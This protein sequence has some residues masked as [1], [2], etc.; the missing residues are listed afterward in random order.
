MNVVYR[1]EHTIAELHAFVDLEIAIWGLAA[2]D[3]VPASL[4]CTVIRN[5]GVLIGAYAE[6]RAQPVGLAFGFPV[7]RGN[8]WLL[9]SHMT[10]VHP[11][12]QRQGIGLELKRRQRQW[13]LNNGFTQMRWTFD[14]LQA[15]N[16]HFNLSLLG[17]QADRYHVDY[18]GEMG[19][20]INAHLPSDRVE[21]VWDL[22]SA[23]TAERTTAPELP[24]S[25]D[26]F[27]L[28]AGPN[29]QPILGST[30]ADHS[31]HLYVEIPARLDL[32]RDNQAAQWR[33]ALRSA[34]QPA[35]ERGFVISG[36]QRKGGR[37]W[38]VLSA[39]QPWFVYVLECADGSLYTGTTKNPA[40][41]IAQH[42]AGLGAAYT[43][44]RRP[45]RY[46]GAWRFPTQADA[47]RAEV[48]FKRQPRPQKRLWLES[49]RQFE[50]GLFERNLPT[51][52]SN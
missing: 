4:L 24:P 16:A 7:R 2:C 15:G 34:L 18:Y 10:G 1:A 29:S 19:D 44:A 39:P 12:F 9:W 17:A 23:E 30:A 48:A 6:G 13:A 47:L 33:L 32:A 31:N 46:L 52:P 49:G 3:A 27:I 41:R 40:R 50:G 45:V 14:P 22:N 21:A 25:F 20:S 43:A 42:N 51:V 8:R 35:V 36:F 11:Q 5:G 28:R 37:C 26:C 38:Y